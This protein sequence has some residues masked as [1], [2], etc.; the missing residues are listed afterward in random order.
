MH[1]CELIDAIG[2]ND[3]EGVRRLVTFH[4][5]MIHED[6]LHR[7]SNWG[8]PLS[9]A[10]TLGRNPIIQMLHQL[11]A[12]DLEHALDR[13][14]LQGHVGTAAMLHQMLGG[15]IPPDGALGG[16]AY[17]LSAGGTEFALRVGARVV[18]DAGERLA[19]VDVVQSAR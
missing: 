10:A 9:Y 12:T 7:D 18:G 16:P 11:G 17:T 4:P 14:T 1:T 6:T 8:P 15:P 5:A 19:P 13:A 3:L 2:A